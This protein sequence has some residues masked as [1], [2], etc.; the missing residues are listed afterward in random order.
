[1]YD[2]RIGRWLEED[3]TGFEAG[4]SNLDRYVRNNPTNKVDPSGLDPESD[5]QRQL[6]QRMFG[7]PV[8]R[9]APTAEKI[10]SEKDAPI[11]LR[12][13]DEGYW[14]VIRDQMSG[15]P[16]TIVDLDPKK[17]IAKENAAAKAMM[18]WRDLKGIEFN[19]YYVGNS[20][21]GPQKFLETAAKNGY[22]SINLFFGHGNGKSDFNLAKELEK[23]KNPGNAPAPL[24]GIGACYATLYNREIPK[25]NRIPNL[26]ENDGVVINAHA[27]VED[28]PMIDAADKIIR[29][30]LQKGEKIQV[31][32]YFGEMAM[33][34]YDLDPKT[35]K[36]KAW[37]THP[38]RYKDW[39]W[40]K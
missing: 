18:E 1:M 31:N 22:G 40:T 14:L 39:K 25:G 27:P 38:D 35:F 11:G 34:T 3:P 6:Q 36:F 30:R 2:T 33:N 8:D 20:D 16:G 5:R 32:L 13:F 9:D 37:A 7:V 15:K 12:F 28:T 17:N 10:Y 4:D 23:L 29:E 21:S 24:F 26:P 19:V